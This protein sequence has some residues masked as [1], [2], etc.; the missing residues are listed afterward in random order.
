[1][2]AF[3]PSEFSSNQKLADFRGK[4]KDGRRSGGHGVNTKGLLGDYDEDSAV[5]GRESLH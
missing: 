3:V 2:G 5:R 4:N 1:M